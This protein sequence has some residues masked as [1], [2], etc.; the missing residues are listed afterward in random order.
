MAPIIKER[1]TRT[2]QSRRASEDAKTKMLVAELAEQELEEQRKYDLDDEP[3]EHVHHKQLQGSIPPKSKVF[4]LVDVGASIDSPFARVR[5][6]CMSVSAPKHRPSIAAFDSLARI[7]TT[8]EATSKP[9]RSKVHL[10][11][12]QAL[13]TAPLKDSKSFTSKESH[14]FD[15]HIKVASDNYA[16]LPMDISWALLREKLPNRTREQLIHY[17][18][19]RRDAVRA[20][21]SSSTPTQGFLSG[22]FRPEEIQIFENFVNEY[23]GYDNPASHFDWERLAKRI[24]TRSEQQLRKRFTNKIKLLRKKRLDHRPTRSSSAQNAVSTPPLTPAI[25]QFDSAPLQTEETQTLPTKS[26]STPSF[27]WSTGRFSPKELQIFDNYVE[28]HGGYEKDPSHIDWELF[29]KTIK[30]RSATQLRAKFVKKGNTGR[31]KQIT[32]TVKGQQGAESP[33]SKKRRLRAMSL[34]NGQ[35][36]PAKTPHRP[37]ADNTESEQKHSPRP[38][39]IRPTLSTR[40]TDVTSPAEDTEETARPTRQAKKRAR[41]KSKEAVDLS[42]DDAAE[43]TTSKRSRRALRGRKP[44]PTPAPDPAST[45]SSRR[46]RGGTKLVKPPISDKSKES[47]ESLDPKVNV[48]CP[49]APQPFTLIPDPN[50]FYIEEEAHLYHN[51]PLPSYKTEGVLPKNLPAIPPPPKLPEL[52]NTGLCSWTYDE[53]T[54]V[55]LADFAA[56]ERNGAHA[57]PI[58]MKGSVDEKFLLSMMERDD[59]TV[60]SEG[61]LDW[62]SMDPQ[63]WDLNHMCAALDKEF[64]HRFRRFDST[65]NSDGTETILEIDE[66]YSMMMCEYGRYLEKRRQYFTMR[67]AGVDTG[68]EATNEFSFVDH[69]GKEHTIDVRVSAL[70]MIDMDIIRQLPDLAVNFDQAFK[71]KSVLPGGKN[72][73][74]NKV[75]PNARPFMGPNMYVTPPASFTHFHQDGHGTVDSGHLVISGYNEVV[76]LRRLTERHK[77][78]ALWLLTGEKAQAEE[79]KPKYFDGL[80]SEPHGDRLGEKPQWPTNTTIE[81]CRNMG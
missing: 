80:Y 74:M 37:E 6:P 17:Y 75:T 20:N 2:R 81:D 34:G 39:S 27:V 35:T 38:G 14:I 28:E 7:G 72:C 21:P 68:D 16:K 3:A 9:P 54:R 4:D 79:S 62:K 40:S 26:S 12:L 61:H 70:Y 29:A 19:R 36:I 5:R 71:Y 15:K 31:K 46:T 55:L 1:S 59:I 65:T 8:P 10:N 66:N 60:I 11:S 73:M 51:P 22:P 30:T 25:P 44:E 23:G 69:Q 78:H 58:L 76:I 41:H 57:T 52:P 42:L 18:S 33:N 63:L 64:F 50:E 53:E 45:E 24:A 77:R 43:A 13:P 49:P 67:E 48:I 47:G 32:V 56:G